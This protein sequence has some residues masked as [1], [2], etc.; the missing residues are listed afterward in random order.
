MER[1][2]AGQVRECH[3]DLH[4][5]NLVFHDGRLQPFDCLEFSP[6]LRWIDIISDIAF[7]AMDLQH[8]GRADLAAV[9]L[10]RWLEHGGEFSGLMT[11]RWYLTYRALV[12][13]KVTALR[14]TSGELTGERRSRLETCLLG[15]LD[16]ARSV[17][18]RHR[19]TL[20]ITHGV[21][22]SGKTCR[23]RQLIRKG[24]WWI[25]LRSD[26]ERLR[27]FGRWPGGPVDPMQ[28]DP[29][30][31]EV[32]E[33]LYHEWLP[34]KAGTAL[35][36]GFSVVVDATFLRRDHRVV[37]AEL[38]RRTGA[39]FAILDCPVSESL[40]RRRIR[41]RLAAGTDASEA[42]VSVLQRQLRN[43]EHLTGEERALVK[44]PADLEAV[45]GR[46]SP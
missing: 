42:D 27:R 34:A 45:A 7:L 38:A 1:K 4:L 31:P 26:V 10:N 23:A 43:Q 17:T 16:L 5:G 28:G 35:A 36:A 12:R 14:L 22:G 19:P 21:S 20:V 39:G 33:A 46:R 11:W 29:Y 15:Y 30:R 37:M 13:A 24:G 44:H 8:R 9:V 18:E 41:R 6:Q 2:A 40:A 32:T 3:G 25:H